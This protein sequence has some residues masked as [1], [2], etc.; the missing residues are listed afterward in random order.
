MDPLEV[1][2]L[3]FPNIS[4]RPSELH[5]PFAAVMKID[6]LSDIVLKASEP[7]MVLFNFYDDWLKSISPYTAFSR[8]ILILRALNID[9]E[10]ANHILR[11]S[12]SIVTQDHHIW[13]S[14]SDEQWVD[15]EAQLRDLIL[16]DYSKNTMSM[17]N[18]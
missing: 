17:S 5:L 15:V 13:P 9:T 16:S 4:I 2:M 3:D 6:K 12:A 11:P 7:Q 14:L 18:R 8:V 1:H 10:T